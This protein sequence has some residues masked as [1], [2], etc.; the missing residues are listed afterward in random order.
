[1]NED[2]KRRIGEAVAKAKNAMLEASRIAETQPQSIGLWK[3]LDAVTGKLEF[4][5][6][7]V[8]HQKVDNTPTKF[9][10]K[11]GVLK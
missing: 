6:R 8:S 11:Q 10:D 9:N 4:I 5:Q 1:M 7:I 3:T 2:A